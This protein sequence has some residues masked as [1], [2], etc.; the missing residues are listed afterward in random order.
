MFDCGE[1]EDQIT[2]FNGKDDT[3]STNCETILS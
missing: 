3:L 1:G 2:D